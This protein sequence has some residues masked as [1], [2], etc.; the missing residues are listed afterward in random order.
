MKDR[1]ERTHV[2]KVSHRFKRGCISIIGLSFALTVTLA[3]V[4][5]LYQAQNQQI[6]ERID[7]YSDEINYLQSQVYAAK[8]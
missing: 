1:I 2:K 8:K 6:S 7:G 4:I 3:S 5:V